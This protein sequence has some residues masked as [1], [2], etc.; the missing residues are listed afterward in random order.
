[1][2]S[3]RNRV[4]F[5]GAYI[6]KTKKLCTIGHSER[7][8]FENSRCFSS[9]HRI[10]ARPGSKKRPPPGK[11]D[12]DETKVGFFVMVPRRGLNTSRKREGKKVKHKPTVRRTAAGRFRGSSARSSRARPGEVFVFG[13]HKANN[14]GRRFSFRPNIKNGGD[15]AVTG[16]SGSQAEGLGEETTVCA[17]RRREL[18]RV[19]LI[20]ETTG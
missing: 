20:I 3:T 18:Y 4:I 10:G 6:L 11:F 9:S 13:A 12:S 17:L 1:M 7:A 16:R 15:G 2:K 8:K 14:P 19:Y 5:Q